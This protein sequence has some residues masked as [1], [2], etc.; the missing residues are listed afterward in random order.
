MPPYDDMI[1]KQVFLELPDTEQ[2][3]VLWLDARQY[4]GGAMAIELKR[5]IKDETHPFASRNSQRFIY[6]I[7]E[8]DSNAL[9]ALTD[10]RDVKYYQDICKDEGV[11]LEAA[12]RLYDELKESNQ[13]VAEKW[14]E[15]YSPNSREL[16][17]KDMSDLYLAEKLLREGKPSEGEFPVIKNLNDELPVTW[18]TT[19]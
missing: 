1:E 16:R 5:I 17:Q 6:L 8:S 11:D 2:N 3:G 13:E 10:K 18:A 19:N 15:V 12:Y 7:S 9:E 14:R 4:S